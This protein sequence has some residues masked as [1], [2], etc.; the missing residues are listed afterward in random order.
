MSHHA[1]ALVRL[2]FHDAVGG[3]GGPNGCLDPN[4]G[5]HGGLQDVVAG[6]ATIFVQ[7]Q[8]IAPNLSLADLWIFA[9][10]V[11]IELTSTGNGNTPV[12]LPFRT[13]R[14]TASSCDDSNLLPSAT[15]DWASQK[16]FWQR[17]NFNSAEIVAIMGCHSLGR[18]TPE[19]TGFL[20]GW[21]FTQSS[22]GNNYFKVVRDL[23]WQNPD[24]NAVTWQESTNSLMM[25]KVDLELFYQTTTSTT[26]CSTINPGLIGTASCPRNLET[27][28]IINDFIADQ[29][30]F[31]SVFIGAW[32]KMVE[33]GQ[34]QLR[35]VV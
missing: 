14:R 22:F 3:G 13:G 1:G 12:V 16:R 29:S 27:V 5:A 23:R 26:F 19:E 20:G 8:I 21:T 32:I 30:H 24:R 11:A 4:Q 9:A 34:T 6:L 17:L 7:T 18:A 10:Q 31:Y 35:D 25:L 33:L 2:A 15:L 28:D